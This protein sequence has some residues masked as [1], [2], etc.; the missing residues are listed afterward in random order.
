VY[1]NAPGRPNIESDEC[2]AI[3]VYGRGKRAAEKLIEAWSSE[4]NCSYTILRISNIYGF[5]IPSARPQGIIHHAINAALTGGALTIWGDGSAQ[6]DFIYYTDFL[7]F[8]DKVIELR[9]V[10]TYNVS[11]GESFSIN[12]VLTAVETQTGREINVTYANAAT[13]DVRDS[14]LSNE[15]LCAEIR[16]TP[17][18]GLTEGIRRSLAM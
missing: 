6:K 8:I 5:T 1:G 18:I 15:R 10:G 3:S 12:E 7:V 16:W 9:P 2:N 14:R 11:L 13:W 4:Y 17:K